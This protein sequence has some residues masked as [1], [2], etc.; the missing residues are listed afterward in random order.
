[1]LD[2][3]LQRVSVDIIKKNVNTLEKILNMTYQ[4]SLICNLTF[5]VSQPF[6]SAYKHIQ[7]LPSCRQPPFVRGC[8]PISLLPFIP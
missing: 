5:S 1:M 7:S 8:Y 6:P 3:C 4:L 2:Q